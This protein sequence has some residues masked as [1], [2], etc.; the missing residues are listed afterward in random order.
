VIPIE[1][2]SSGPDRPGLGGGL[3]ELLPRRLH[4]MTTFRSMKLR[5]D[6][7][8][9][10]RRGFGD[11]SPRE[12]VRL[13]ER[14]SLFSVGPVRRRKPAR[15]QPP[16]LRPRR[17]RGIS[18]PLPR[19]SVVLAPIGVGEGREVTKAGPVRSRCDPPRI[20][21]CVESKRR[22]DGTPGRSKLARYAAKPRAPV[23]GYQ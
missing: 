20:L 12:L 10:L 8:T 18:R 13:A 21:R 1:S 23:I 3:Q 19:P 11:T 7:A 5:I 16:Q 4:R 9:G 2:G 22:V 14:S 15:E 17:R 6:E